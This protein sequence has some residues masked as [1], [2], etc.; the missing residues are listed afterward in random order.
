MQPGQDGNG[1]NDTRPLDWSMQGRIYKPASGELVRNVE[2][3]ISKD[4]TGWLAPQCKLSPA[5]PAFPANREFYRE[6]FK[7]A[8][9]G[10]PETANSGRR[11]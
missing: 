10:T 5:L 4:G 11:C 1:D 7:I 3:K 9:F 8:L 6:F 2:E